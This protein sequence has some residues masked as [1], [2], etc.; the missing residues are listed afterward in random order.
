MTLANGLHG[1]SVWLAC[2]VGALESVNVQPHHKGSH[3]RKKKTRKQ[4]NVLRT[5][6]QAVLHVLGCTDVASGK[7][8]G[9]GKPP[10]VDSKR[11]EHGRSMIHAGVPSS[12]GFS[13]AP[14][15][16]K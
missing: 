15:S 13:G 1:H 5:T 11:L 10:T 7:I 3:N 2:D 16:A 12:W 6:W 4:H 9:R 14:K 8:S